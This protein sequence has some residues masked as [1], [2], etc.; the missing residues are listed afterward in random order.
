MRELA[1]GPARK[2]RVWI[3]SLPPYGAYESISTKIIDARAQ[4]SQRTAIR[5]A[6][7]DWWRF[8]G[9]KLNHAMLGGQFTPSSDTRWRA[10]VP[11]SAADGPLTADTILGADPRELVHAGL[12]DEYVRGLE[13]AVRDLEASAGGLHAGTLTISRAAHGEIAG[14]AWAFS[15]AMSCLVRIL[16]AD[17]ADLTDDALR[18]MLELA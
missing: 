13:L 8:T 3:A 5:T 7:I 1:F 14:C 12:P 6:A 17:P 2:A 9:A 11:I 10:V 18:A 4:T 16:Q 15:Q